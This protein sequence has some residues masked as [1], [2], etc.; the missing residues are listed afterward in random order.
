MGKDLA[1]TF[2]PDCRRFA[3]YIFLKPTRFRLA[4]VA[5]VQKITVAPLEIEFFGV[6]GSTQDQAEMQAGVAS[7]SEGDETLTLGET[8][9]MFSGQ[10]KYNLELRML[11]EDKKVLKSLRGLEI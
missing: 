3:K 11:N 8:A 9:Q 4:P 6:T 7:L 2:E 1:I 10:T 5:H